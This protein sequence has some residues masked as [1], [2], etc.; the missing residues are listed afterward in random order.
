MI[1]WIQ[2]LGCEGGRGIN[3]ME[4]ANAGADQNS[5]HCR[6][7]MGPEK[8]IHIVYCEK[9]LQHAPLHALSKSTIDIMKHI[10]LKS[11]FCRE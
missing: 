2:D 7:Q 11:L 4:D 6:H 10:K 5:L 9:M 3:Y 1:G 8:T